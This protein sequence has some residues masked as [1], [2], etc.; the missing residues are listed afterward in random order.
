MHSSSNLLQLWLRE[1]RQP[2]FRLLWVALFV[3]VLTVASITA[4]TARLKMVFDDGAAR[5]LGGDQAVESTRR[6]PE[7]WPVLAAENG[8]QSGLILQFATM[9]RGIGEAAE[10]QYQ[11]VA[12]KA[13][14]NGYPLKGEVGISETPSGDMETVHRGPG[15]GEI[16]LAPR[17]FDAFG[18]QVGDQ[19]AIGQT[20]LTIKAV[21]Q[22]EPDPNFSF[23]NVAPRVLMHFDDVASTGVVQPGSRLSYRLLLAGDDLALKNFNR[24]IEPQMTVSDKIVRVREGSP[25][26]SNAIDKAERYLLLGSVLGVLLAAVALT[27]T[28]QFYAQQ[29]KDTVALLK[30]L[31]SQTKQLSYRYA[32][33]L[34]L[35]SV[36]AIAAGLTAGWMAERW[37]A[38]SLRDLL[39]PLSSGL[40]LTWVWLPIVTLVIVL[41]AFA[42]PVFWSL[43]KEPPMIILR[44]GVASADMQRLLGFSWQRLLIAA[45]GF[46]LLL[47]IYS[48]E[49]M[50]VLAILIGLG[51]MIAVATLLMRFWLMV[52]PPKV[53][54]VPGALRA[55]TEQLK[56]RPW[57]TV[58]HILALGSAWSLLI[59]LFLVRTELID[60]WQAQI[61]ENAPN[62][63]LVNVA[64]YE[65]EPI[66]QL[67]KENGISAAPLYPMVRGRLTHIN[68]V[69]VKVAVTK[70]EE[71]GA[72]NRELNLTW[73][74]QLPADNKLLEGQWWSSQNSNASGV[75]IESQLAGRLGVGLGDRLRFTIGDRATEVDI[76]SIR[77]VQ[78]DSLK[79]N[80]YFAFEPGALDDFA[81][82]YITSAFITPEQKNL[83][84]RINRD[85]PTVSVLE[86]D[87]FVVKI[88]EVIAQVTMAIEAL[89]ILIF[90]AALLVVAALLAREVPVRQAETALYRALGA[91]R[92]VVVQAI[93][94]EFALIGAISGVLGIIVAEAVAG[95][96]QYRMFEL[97]FTPHLGVWALI[98]LI[99]AFG[100]A[101]YARWR[102]QQVLSTPPH[103]ALQTGFAE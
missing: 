6:M 70:E 95:F 24:A 67:I 39:P 54:L 11:L 97:P 89:L 25:A 37:I 62:H 55:G 61:P 4:F 26:V 40:P 103:R 22:K 77:S 34:G 86:L 52:N 57:S 73:M 32:G 28:A 90:A 100:T 27:I 38:W 9:L 3:A 42:W 85:F 23:V 47:W 53:T 93:F 102:L 14:N 13:V 74:E 75:S 68:D 50:I 58:P 45:V 64:E 72:L 36:T 69:E 5:F 49:P 59:T 80:F 20:P 44:Q 30:T 98:P 99:S 21:I 1:W 65:V 87:Q 48:G 51:A 66:Q 12:V 84:N 71:V 35:S 29:Q 78:W 2:S 19:V 81:A 88:R 15:P 7:G 94:G 91:H 17:L 56:R 46:G 76:T 82:I 10:D 31:G 41:V 63:F 60:N 16:W 33:M 8:L 92:K 101:Y 43:C 79:P 83:I 96:L 18:V